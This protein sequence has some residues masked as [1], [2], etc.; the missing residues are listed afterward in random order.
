[1]E[2]PNY[3]TDNVLNLMG[4]LLEGLGGETAG[5]AP[6]TALPPPEVGE[7]RQVVLLLI[8][9]LGWEFLCRDREPGCLR[10]LAR[11]RLGSVFP[12]TTAAA[13]T[14]F[15]TGVAPQQHGLTGW[16]MYFREL[17]AVLSV[18]PGV[19]RYGG[20]PLGKAGVDVREFFGHRAIF[21]RIPV[22]S[23]LVTPR[24]IAH[25]DFNR[26]HQGSA[27]LRPFETLQDFFSGIGTLL[28]NDRSRKFIYA[29]WADFDRISHEAGTSGA[30]T[31]RHFR[32]LEEDFMRFLASI[33]GT[34]TLVILTADHGFIDT[35]AD[36][37]V[38]LEDHPELADCLALPLCG[39]RRLAYCYVKPGATRFFEGYVR[40]ELSA[41]AELWESRE[42][43]ERGWFGLGPAHSRLA[44]RIGDYT[45]VMKE[46]YCVKD[47][48]PG[49]LRYE[50]IGVHGG[51][52]EPEMGV[53]LIVAAA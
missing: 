16:H 38:T 28:R 36:H 30:E 44:D 42:L 20:C 18:L 19:P 11:T 40:S 32:S 8:D 37:T 35:D 47:W 31:E 9:G 13:V 22:Q 34:G 2:L 43:I 26:A 10:T 41:A 27:V 21:D 46:N 17:G 53:P 25:S 24:R 6:L 15:L 14:S 51:V 23:Y 49:E 52:S 48:L 7:Y 33:A 4:S 3:R 45:L 1:M 12:S 5:Y 29:Y 50:Q 39:E